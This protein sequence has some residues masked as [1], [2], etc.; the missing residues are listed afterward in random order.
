MTWEMQVCVSTKFSTFE[1]FYGKIYLQNTCA[2]LGQAAANWWPLLGSVGLHTHDLGV[3][4]AVEECETYIETCFC[5]QKMLWIAKFLKCLCAVLVEHPAFVASLDSNAWDGVTTSNF[6]IQY[7]C[8]LV[9]T[10]RTYLMSSVWKPHPSFPAS[11][12]QMRCPMMPFPI[13]GYVWLLLDS[14]DVHCD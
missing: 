9:G 2:N 1:T 7:R 5:L 8:T 12:S 6:L 3:V 13:F 10:C 14:L 4:C 11:C